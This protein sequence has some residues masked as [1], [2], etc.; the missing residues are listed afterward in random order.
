MRPILII[1]G[2][3]LV[4]CTGPKNEPAG[5][6]PDT[7]SLVDSACDDSDADGVCDSED[8]C[9][10]FDD[11]IDVNGNAIP[12]GCDLYLCS[13][14]HDQEQ[15]T[16]RAIV[17]AGGDFERASSHVGGVH[18][19]DCIVCHDIG[20]HEQ[21]TVELVAPDQGSISAY[22]PADP[23]G[24]EPF[25]TG[26]HDSDGAAASGGLVPFSD[27]RIATNVLATWP[28]SSHALDPFAGNNDQPISCFGDGLT[29]GCHGNAH[30]SDSDKLVESTNAIPMDTF[31]AQYCHQ[32]Q[33]HAAGTAFGAG[34]FNYQMAC[35]SCHN[36]HVLTGTESGQTTLTLPDF[37]RPPTENPRAMGTTLWGA[38]PGEKMDDIAGTGTYRVPNGDLVEGSE[39]ADYPTFCLSCHG[40]SDVI[41][42]PHGSI[43]WGVDEPHGAHSANSPD[44]QEVC[45]DW[46]SCGK[47]AGWTGDDCTSTEDVCWPVITRGAGDETW[48]RSPYNHTERI[49]GANFVLSCSDCHVSHGTGIGAMIRETVNDGPGDTVWNTMCDNCHYYYSSVHAGQACP[50]CH[51]TQSIHGMDYATGDV[52][53]RSFDPDLVVAYEFEGDLDDGGDWR[54]HGGW[55]VSPGAYVPGFYGSG[56]EVDD[57]PVEVGTR[58][59]IWSTDEGA[60]GTWKYTEMKYNMTLEAW[61]QPYDDTPDEQILMAK[62]TYWDGGYALTLK[63]VDGTLR[64][65]LLTNVAGGG[66]DYTAW[67]VAGCNGLRGAF[68]SIPI[69][70]DAWSHVAAT[71]DATLPD[72]DDLDG[73]VGRIRIW[74]N[75]EDVTDS[76]DD[77]DTCYAQPGVG[78]TTMFP[79]SEHSPANETL[80]FEYHWCG[81]A[82]SVGGLNWSAPENYVGILDELKIWNITQ[83]DPYFDTVDIVAPPRIAFVE[84]VPGSDLLVV[85]FSE[86]TYATIFASGALL[87][88]D[89]VFTDLDDGRTVTAV[90]HNP[91]DRTATLTL[92]SPLDAFDDILVDTLA[93]APIGVFDEHGNAADSLAAGTVTASGLCPPLT[94]VIFDLDEA[95]GSAFAVDDQGIAAGEVHGAGLTGSEFSGNGLDTYIDFE[96]HGSC[97]QAATAMTI[98]ARIQPTGAGILGTANHVGRIFARDSANGNYQLSVWRNN[99]WDNYEAPT[100]TASIALWVKPV[101]ARGG[102]AWKLALTDFGLCPI[103]QD[104]WYQIKAVWNSAK[105][106]GIPAD[107]W[108]DDQG[109]DGAD[110]GES[111]AGLVN[112]TDAAQVLLTSDRY[113]YE[114]DEIDV[115][116]GD[117]TIG[118]SV[119]NHTANV[120]E[121]L[122]DWISWDDQAN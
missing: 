91:G 119:N 103:V 63:K 115:A 122:I 25:C 52:N 64:A 47:A 73:S 77:V 86:E 37:T 105:V 72:R 40:I 1:I 39:L 8:M 44:G 94:P 99:S 36:P 20:N 56:I 102:M 11:L 81:S 89:F 14:C 9:P 19:S 7:D 109:T 114:G 46:A 35:T 24:L 33:G 83:E 95:P 41:F 118:A 27:G 22:D 53:V 17:G 31:C 45:P 80:C 121:G 78:E 29:T 6:P 43:D 110:A 60:H 54:L 100:D 92:S 15:G 4:S 65:G 88:A 57:D 74:V 26:C 101:D 30:G 71:Y 12:D 50:D 76:F 75:G 34:N 79:Y 70:V 66:P 69:P 2:A 5:N 104:H 32:D 85:T 106:G 59:A 28:S 67:D 48:S 87:P 107:I 111:W 51:V 55:R 38:D 82:L 97:L 108:V 10:G 62:H 117:F 90:T 3:C 58:D 16:R 84:G 93:A 18:D 21:G 96:N 13:S 116:D 23:A 120:F 68:S 61:I 42:G 98:E 113:L 49:D 112:C